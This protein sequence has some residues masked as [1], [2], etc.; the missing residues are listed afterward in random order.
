MR[1]L[2]A[3]IASL[4][5]LAGCSQ[6]IPIDADKLVE[7]VTKNDTI[8]EL[9]VPGEAVIP[10]AR[11]AQWASELSKFVP[12]YENPEFMPEDK[13]GKPQIFQNKLSKTATDL[14]ATTYHKAEP[15]DVYAWFEANYGKYGYQL[16]AQK[17]VDPKV[18]IIVEEHG[19]YILIDKDKT[20]EIHVWKLNGYPGWSKVTYE[21]TTYKDCGCD[22]KSE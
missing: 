21:G 18:Y 19:Y 3:V 13:L 12:V 10:F 5:I 9:A 15:R 17:G 14:T 22:K 7:P 11:N 16:D 6:E 1:K 8:P 4:A 2:I 20:M